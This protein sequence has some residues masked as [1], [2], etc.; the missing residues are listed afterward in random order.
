MS[1]WPN[2]GGLLRPL[3]GLEERM[4]EPNTVRQ[5]RSDSSQQASSKP[6]VVHSMTGAAAC[7]TVCV[8]L[9]KLMATCRQALVE[10]LHRQV[11]SEQT[12]HAA[13]AGSSRP[14]AR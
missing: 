7:A 9:W 1:T 13:G 12:P 6:G 11:Q 8:V 10:W 14:G 4:T 3:R 5:C 2:R